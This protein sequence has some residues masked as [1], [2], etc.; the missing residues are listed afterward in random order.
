MV[1]E[2]G[3]AS[4]C[5]LLP[6]CSVLPADVPFREVLIKFP[7][8]DRA[9]GRVRAGVAGWAVWQLPPALRRYVTAV[10]GA[11]VAAMV[12]AAAMLAS[13]TARDAVLFAALAAFGAA[14]I[15]LTRRTSEPAGAIKDVHGIW[16]V[17]VALLLPPVYALAAPAVTF[18]LLQARTRRTVLHRQVFSAAAS[19]LGLAAASALFSLL[20]GWLSRPEPAPGAP[21]LGWLATAAGCALIW[22]AAGSLLVAGA[23]RLADR[24][25]RLRDQLLTRE[26]MLNDGSEM[27]AGL[28]LAAAVGALGPVLLLPA[29]PLVIVLQRSCRHAQLVSA[30]RIDAK[31]GLLNAAAWRAEATVALTRAA[32]TRTP[33]AVLMADLDHFKQVNDS[34]GHLA[35]DALLAR[36]AAVMTALLRDYDLCGRFGGE[37][38]AIL[39]PHT[40]ATQATDIAERLRSRVAALSI[41]PAGTS[42]IHVT[43]SVGVATLHTARRDLDDLLAAADTALYAAKRGGRNRVIS[44]GE[45]GQ[46]TRIPR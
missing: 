32:R 41:S 29:L 37:E 46:Q 7:A 30:A 12:A 40:G 9:P 31:T 33:A 16:L 25:V 42:A 35:G 2:T 11:A 13:W 36:V 23:V 6:A 1:T 34:H 5:R 4:Y 17:P 24:T 28:L 43:L 19:G 8:A 3:S 14:A 44:I 10:I 39:L 21:M 20:R 26:A 45:D 27:A 18:T 38:F 15:E 22:S